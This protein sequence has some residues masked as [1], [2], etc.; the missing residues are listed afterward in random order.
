MKDNPVDNNNSI[1]L[2][3]IYFNVLVLSE[4]LVALAQ[5]NEWET[6]LSREA[7][8]VV[9]VENLTALTQAFE[10][11]QPITEEFIQL[12]Q[13]II[14]N[15][16]ITKESLQRHLN[17]LSKEIKQ[18]DQKRVLNNSYGQFAEVNAPIIIKPM[19]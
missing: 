5:S 15:E 8:Y 2:R 3:E 14:E 9:A 6:L 18:L 1:D 10:E 11:T 16:R 17:F 13:R 7:E 19:Q 4:N 12:L